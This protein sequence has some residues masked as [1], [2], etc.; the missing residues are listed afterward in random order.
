MNVNDMC[1][2]FAQFQAIIT[3]LSNQAI[4]PSSIEYQKE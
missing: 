4:V 1:K 3:R 2:N